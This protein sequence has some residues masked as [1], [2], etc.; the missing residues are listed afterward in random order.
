MLVSSGDEPDKHAKKKRR[1][2]T[3][4]VPLAL[5]VHPITTLNINAR[6]YLLD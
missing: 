1:A 4:S 3:P 6:L 2:G 5:P